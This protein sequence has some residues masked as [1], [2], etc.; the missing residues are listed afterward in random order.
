M[1]DSIQVGGAKKEDRYYYFNLTSVAYAIDSS[2]NT[3]RTQL[4]FQFKPIFYNLFEF[5]ATKPTHKS[6]SSTP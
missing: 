1:H 6:I 4:I 3:L 2:V 5:S